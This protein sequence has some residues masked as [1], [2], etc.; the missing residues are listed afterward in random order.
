MRS[1][2]ALS[3]A[4][5]SAAAVAGA[6]RR[7]WWGGIA[8]GAL[9]LALGAGGAVLL[10]S[11]WLPMVGG[12]SPRLG[13]MEAR[14]AALEEVPPPPTSVTRIDEELRATVETL[15]GELEAAGARI[16]ERDARLETAET[17]LAQLPALVERLAAAEDRLAAGVAGDGAAPSLEALEATVTRV[18]A[19][20]DRVEALGSVEAALG[21]VETAQGDARARLDEVAGRVEGLAALESRIAELAALESRVDDLA[22]LEGQISGLAGRVT[23]VAA[24][25]EAGRESVMGDAA[26]LLGVLQLRDA[27]QGSGAFAEEFALLQDLAAADI[28]GPEGKLGELIQPL[29]PLAERGVPSLAALKSE[30]PGVAS[31][32][33]AEARGETGPEW[34]AGVKRQVSGLVT[35]RQLRPADDDMSAGAVVARAEAALMSDDLAGAIAALEGLEG[36]PAQAARDWGTRAGTR[37]LAERTV[38]AL[39]RLAIK[40][41]RPVVQ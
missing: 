32:V 18:A 25:A 39:S 22:A 2:A 21:G 36:A 33:I 27:M 35:V 23:E 20:E 34:L 6:R 31:A 17:E 11:S 1:G 12:S 28:G 9:L 8:L 24:V 30:F 37:L 16:L 38:T 4:A 14:I 29:A 26:L 15:Q 41:L 40:D 3:E 13:A 19:L 7:A 5:L 10:R